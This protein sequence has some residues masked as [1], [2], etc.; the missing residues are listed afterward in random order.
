MFTITG[1]GMKLSSIL[2]QLSGGQLFPLL[3]LM[4][5][6]NIILGMG[7]PTTAVYIILATLAA[8]T[9]IK[10]GLSPMCAHLFVFY[11]GC[12]SHL[13]PPV[14]LAA[15][16]AAGLA[17]S[18]PMKT[19]FAAWRIGLAGFIVPFMFVYGPALILEDSVLNIIVAFITAVVGVW[20]LAISLEGYLFRDFPWWQRT[21]PFSASLLLIK[22]GI[23]TDLM[24]LAILG[25][26]LLYQWKLSKKE[27]VPVP[28]PAGG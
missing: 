27:F 20:A 9:L 26:F 11:Y 3:V 25:P 13:T 14:A 4:A 23:Y 17:E 5:I 12:L 8:P 28:F 7:M 22:P 19:G 6:C 10:L 1:L 2:I 16:A 21:I 15:Y 18:P 24:G